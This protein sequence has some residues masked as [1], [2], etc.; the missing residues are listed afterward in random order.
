MG[1]KDESAGENTQKMNREVCVQANCNVPANFMLFL[2]ATNFVPSAW[3]FF[4]ILPR[5]VS[6]VF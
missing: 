5:L 1:K 3:M 2:Q 6:N 4:D